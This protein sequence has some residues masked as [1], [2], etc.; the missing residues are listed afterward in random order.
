LP[1][2]SF[3][4]LFGLNSGCSSPDRY[5]WPYLEHPC[6]QNFRLEKPEIASVFP[7][8]NSAPQR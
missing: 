2:L 7:L 5:F 1:R 4:R 6:E 3:L 8:L